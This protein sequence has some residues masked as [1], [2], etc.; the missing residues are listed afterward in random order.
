MRTPKLPPGVEPPILKWV[1][2]KATIMDFILGALPKGKR[3]V[4]PFVGSGSVF[5]NSD[6]P[7]YL[8]A[9]TNADLINLFNLTKNDPDALC[10]ELF[11]IWHMPDVRCEKVYYLLREEL[12]ASPFSPHPRHC[13][14]FLY[15]NRFGY[16]GLCRYSKGNKFNVPFGWYKEM[17]LMPVERIQSFSK[18]AREKNAEFLCQDFAETMRMLRE[19]DVVYCDPPYMPLNKCGFTDYKNRFAVEEQER[20]ANEVRAAVDRLH[21]VEVFV[22]NH[23]TDEV[24]AL[25]KDAK[26][27]EKSVQRHIARR[28]EE[29]RCVSELL[30]HFSSSR[31]GC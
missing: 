23:A 10:D 4:E 12:N 27:S 15:L 17:P 26:F 20:L 14:L 2:G 31:R 21:S 19:G 24:R 16:N 6:Y 3:L 8:L 29:W 22:S 25:Y 9:D 11:R 1:G 7:E 28:S 5:L 30:A 18:K 13:A